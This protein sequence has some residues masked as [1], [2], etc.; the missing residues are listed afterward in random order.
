MIIYFTVNKNNRVI[1]ILTVKFS[2]KM[3]W[4]K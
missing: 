1:D 3:C 2:Y 4:L